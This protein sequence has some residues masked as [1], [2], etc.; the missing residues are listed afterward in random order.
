MR[1]GPTSGSAA[2]RKKT[3]YDALDTVSTG[4]AIEA[5]KL[6]DAWWANIRFSTYITSISEH[7]DREDLHGRLSMDFGP[8]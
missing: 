1:G 4:V 8:M 6:F 2:A 3:F 5:M 7:D